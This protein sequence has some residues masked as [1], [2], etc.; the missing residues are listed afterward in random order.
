M[1]AQRRRGKD[2]LAVTCELFQTNTTLM[3]PPLLIYHVSP[4]LFRVLQHIHAHVYTQWDKVQRWGAARRLSDAVQTHC[5]FRDRT[6]TQ[7]S[8]CDAKWACTPKAVVHTSVWALLFYN[9]LHAS[10]ADSTFGACELNCT[11]MCWVWIVLCYLSPSQ[12][13][14]CAVGESPFTL[15]PQSHTKAV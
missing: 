6:H 1:T 7:V 15:H 5:S 4:P 10:N 13:V 2:L 3:T 12:I 11:I 9:K 14:H 8:I